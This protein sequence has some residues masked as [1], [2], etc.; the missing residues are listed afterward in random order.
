MTT[1][2][3]YAISVPGSVVTEQT[4]P[5]YVKRAARFFL[6]KS[7]AAAWQV[8]AEIEG[9]IVSAGLLTWEQCERLE[10]EAFVSSS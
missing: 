9:R 1:A 4:A 2:K 3:P 8:L 7:D 5:V 6:S 10:I